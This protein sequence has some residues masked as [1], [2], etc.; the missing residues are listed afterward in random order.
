MNEKFS[1]VPLVYYLMEEY[2]NKNRN[3][4]RKQQMFTLIEEYKKSD[5]KQ[6][7][8]CLAKGIAYSTFQRWLYLYRAAKSDTEY[9]TQQSTK[10]FIPIT[11]PLRQKSADSVCLIDYPNGVRVRLSNVDE[12]VISSLIQCYQ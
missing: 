9:Q 7:E 10:D 11:S 8:F 1:Y 5:Q 6:K 2:M 3:S 12:K 4:S